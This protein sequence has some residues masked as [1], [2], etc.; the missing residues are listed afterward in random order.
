MTEL[1]PAPNTS[2]Y[3]VTESPETG[4]DI[5]VVVSWWSHPTP[6]H[7]R[8]LANTA[9][10]RGFVRHH[11]MNEHMRHQLKDLDGERTMLELTG[12]RARVLHHPLAGPFGEFPVADPFPDDLEH[13]AV[14]GGLGMYVPVAVPL[15]GQPSLQDISLLPTSD[16]GTARI[17]F[18]PTPRACYAQHPADRVEQM[19]E[20]T[21]DAALR[22]ALCMLYGLPPGGGRF[23]L[24]ASR[25]SAR[26]ARPPGESATALPGKWRREAPAPSSRARRGVG[27]SRTRLLV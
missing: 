13:A 11:R 5:P 3:H 15:A 21:D 25:R 17:G 22:S 20:G 12:T 14:T 18:V 27:C 19:I 9:A 8:V 10:I 2:S 16:F 7:L 24:S 4:L 23:F 6:D 26:F 1:P